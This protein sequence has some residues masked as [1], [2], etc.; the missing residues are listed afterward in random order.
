MWHQVS[1]TGR[2]LKDHLRFTME[3][4][5]IHVSQLVQTIAAQGEAS[6]DEAR[7]Y[8]TCFFDCMMVLGVCR[9]TSDGSVQI[10]GGPA[11]A[12]ARAL[13][14]AIAERR[15][16]MFNFSGRDRA[17]RGSGARFL[18]EL[19][20]LRSVDTDRDPTREQDYVVIL[21]TAKM[22]GR[23]AVLV[24]FDDAS[25][26][27]AK[28]IGGRV[29]PEDTNPHG[30][31]LREIREEV[32]AGGERGSQIQL[33]A[34]TTEPIE[35]SGIS[36]TIGAYTRYR[37]H[38]FAAALTLP[39]GCLREEFE[40]ERGRR[41]GW[42]HVDRIRTDAALFAQENAID[43]ILGNRWLDSVPLSTASSV[44]LVREEVFLSHGSCNAQDADR[45]RHLIEGSTGLKVFLA[46]TSVAA[47]DL[48]CERLRRAIQGCR[49][50]CIL[51]T[52]ES[53]ASDWVLIE[54]AVAWGLNKPI[55]PILHGVD[56]SRLPPQLLRHQ[57]VDYA[58]EEQL[59]DRLRSE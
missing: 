11:S 49:F 50:L 6:E 10:K 8:V 35:Y 48:W 15:H 25:W 54:W 19:E 57:T 38:V 56:A 36:N 26:G 22:E 23:T 46:P 32:V 3:T 51:L 53:L 9:R 47:G 41:T 44:D 30:A 24:Q 39:S 28:L 13:S 42:V 17:E 7:G 5:R 52:E 33:T 12:T 37:A 43:R 40:G 21:I 4:Q 2:V 18:S 20:E 14:L 55:L 58:D 31:A 45:L 1:Y 16:G 29:A 27:G 34:L 59:L